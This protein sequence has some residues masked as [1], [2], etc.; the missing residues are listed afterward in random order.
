MTSDSDNHSSKNSNLDQ[1]KT[2]DKLPTPE[3]PASSLE[4]GT[5]STMAA[6]AAPLPTFPKLKGQE[7]WST[8]KFQMFNF[9]N[10]DDLWDVTDP[11][12]EG[13]DSLSTDSATKLKQRKA[14]AKINLMI[15]PCCI[16]HVRNTVTPSQA[17]KNLKKAYESSGLSRR[18]R[19]LRNL[20]NVRLE[21][22]PTMT[23][24]ISEVLNLSQQLND[25]SAPLDDEFIGVILLSGLTAD[26]DA[27]V[28]ALEHSQTKITSD[29]IKSKLLDHADK[30][31]EEN[32]QAFFA[33]KRSNKP[34]KCYHCGLLGHRTSN[35]RKKASNNN[36]SKTTN[37]NKPVSNNIKSNDDTSSSKKPQNK[38]KLTFFSA[39]AS[40]KFTS[41]DWFLDSGASSHHM[42][43]NCNLLSDYSTKSNE[44]VK[45]ANN[46]IMRAEG[47]GNCELLLANCEDPITV[48]DVLYFPDLTVNLLSVSRLTGKNLSVTFDNSGARICD[49]YGDVVATASCVN[50]IYRLDVADTRQPIPS[51]A[52][53]TE[54]SEVN[55]FHL[56]N[57]VT[58][59]SQSLW[60]RRLGHLNIRSMNLLKNGLATGINYQCEQINQPCEQCI[61]GKQTALPFSKSTSRA[62]DF[63]Q[64]IHS[65]LCGPMQTASHN[66]A[67]YVITF[68]DDYSRKTWVYFMKLKSEAFSKFLY[69][70]NL[71]E[72]Q[73]DCKVKCLRTDNGKEYDNNQF[74]NFFKQQGIQHQSSIEYTPQQNG[75]AERVNR[76]LLEK[77]RCMLFD[78]NLPNS[79]WAEAVYHATYLKN[80]SP[81]RAIPNHTPEELWSNKPTNLSE[82]KIF[83]CKA[84]SLVP[85][86]KRKKLDP[87]SKI[88]IFCWIL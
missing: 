46:Q 24:Y 1:S 78:A 59:D 57:V 34:P 51:S 4:Q 30:K 88:L 37:N 33:S 28:L 18:L 47:Q 75:V 15:E 6:G 56:V 81:S 68:T 26:F 27:M 69:F 9:L 36:Q 7:N 14:S 23:E 43:N 72:K 32:S 74:Y 39:L 86:Q 76:T 70:K 52:T 40:F 80:R 85:K 41:N 55:T 21:N 16:V 58:Q 19:L 65:D 35:C 3:S 61:L 48:T 67:K 60:H 8:W 20:F 11:S 79:Y 63:L 5:D 64:I 38:G 50:G 10:Y 54:N 77:A 73:K 53:N 82:L 87:K 17:W 25:I 29:L 13:N 12:K 44:Q 83:G 66:G 2:S 84:Y 22:F 62:N 45:T 31:V 49:S 71:V 42:T